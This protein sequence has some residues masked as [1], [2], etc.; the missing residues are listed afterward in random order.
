ML[1]VVVRI[2]DEDEVDTSALLMLDAA[3][4]DVLVVVDKVVDGDEDTGV[5]LLDGVIGDVFVVVG[6]TVDE[7][8]VRLLL[9]LVV[10]D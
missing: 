10:V 5:L 7:D 3:I 6:E 9:I 1:V 4:E 8:E 2:A